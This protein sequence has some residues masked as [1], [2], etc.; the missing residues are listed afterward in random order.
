MIIDVVLI[1]V[2]PLLM[3]MAY[4]WGF[5]EWVCGNSAASNGDLDR[6]L[7]T[8]HDNGFVRFARPT[9]SSHLWMAAH[10]PTA[11]EVEADDDLTRL[12]TSKRQMAGALR[13]GG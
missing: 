13:H 5:L 8:K 1:A 11:E 12:A 2:L 3:A 7:A 4:L 9:R 10:R 6:L